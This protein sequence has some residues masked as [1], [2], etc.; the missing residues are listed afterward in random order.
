MLLGVAAQHLID[1]VL[2]VVAA[3]SIVLE[4][5]LAFDR[6]LEKRWRSDIPFPE[7][8]WP[9]PPQADAHPHPLAG[10]TLALGGLGEQTTRNGES[11]SLI[12]D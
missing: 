2:A 3:D 5:P 11:I 12:Y 6:I 9:T 8:R 4:E 1:R 10:Q 7:R